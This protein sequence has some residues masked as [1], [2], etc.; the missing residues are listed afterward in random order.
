MTDVEP[1]GLT[2][3]GR[4]T[5]RSLRTRNFRLFFFGQ[6]V[7]NSGNW[8]TNVALTLLVLHFTNSGIAVGALTAAQFGPIRGDA[9]PGVASA[10]VRPWALQGSNLRPPPCKSDMARLTASE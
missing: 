9:P 2:G 7:S 10:L 1:T 3:A 8:L 5:F 4:R 6:L